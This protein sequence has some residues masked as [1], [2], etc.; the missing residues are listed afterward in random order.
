MLQRNYDDIQDI[1][2][3][4][5]ALVLKKFYCNV[6]NRNGEPYA[7]KTMISLRYGLQKTF[8]KTHKFDI[9]NDDRFKEANKI[10]HACLKKLKMEGG[11]ESK[12]KEIISEEDIRKLY[13]TDT[14][15]T[16]DPKSL[17]FKVFFELMMFLCNRGRE[18]LRNMT[19]EDFV[20]NTGASGRRYVVNVKPR[21]TKN[22]Q[23][24]TDDVDDGG[25][26][27][28]EKPG[29]PHCPVLSFEKYLTKLNPGCHFLWQRPKSFQAESEDPSIWYD[30]MVLGKNSLGQM[31]QNISKQADLSKVYSNH[32]IRATCITLLDESGYEG[33]H[34]MTVSK[35]KSETSLKH[36]VSKA[37]EKK[38][39]EMSNALAEQVIP[40]TAPAPEVITA[41][42][43]DNANL[44]NVDFLEI[45]SQ[46]LNNMMVSVLEQNSTVAQS[47]IP[48]PSTVNNQITCV[49]KENV[50]PKYSF[51][52][53]SVVINDYGGKN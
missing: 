1:P 27:M 3:E 30:N 46:E 14:L 10:F 35:H 9:V 28:Y 33:R 39:R 36:Y 53:C 41:T 37:R 48:E 17:Q 21:L 7:K 4:E 42:S 51:N 12:H 16:K 43:S 50:C 26:R 20:V 31:M 18:N 8:E 6:R 15:S 44:E 25:G 22:H 2:A 34:I 32:C 38:K 24:G 5:L 45:D 13:S 11:G 49:S 23:G 52:N 19:K 29:T 40:Q 47:N